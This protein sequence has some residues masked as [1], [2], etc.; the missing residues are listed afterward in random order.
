MS[1]PTR[2]ASA[3]AVSTRQVPAS[4]THAPRRRRLGPVVALT[5]ALTLAAACSADDTSIAAPGGEAPTETL[6]PFEI[7]ET[8]PVEA[9]TGAGETAAGGS[10]PAAASSPLS[11]P[12]ARQLPGPGA[13]VTTVPMSATSVVMSTPPNPDEASPA[14]QPD[15]VGTPTP[16]YVIGAPPTTG[17]APTTSATTQPVE[18]DEPAPGCEGGL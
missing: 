10:A 15:A 17:S 5:V 2:P 13:T 3:T 18:P 12:G 14:R 6:A 9:C 11:A 8:G 16:P 4:A 1:P 7:D